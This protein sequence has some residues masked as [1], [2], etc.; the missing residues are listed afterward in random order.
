MGAFTVAAAISTGGLALPLVIGAAIGAGGNLIGQG[1]TNIAHGKNF[2]S[3][4]SWESVV[5]SGVAGAALA[6]G[7]GGTISSTVIGAVANASI[8]CFNDE[9]VSDIFLSGAV[10]G[11]A[12]G[13]GYASGKLISNFIY[14]NSGFTFSTFYK[15]ALLDSGRITAAMTAFRS[16]WYTFLPSLFSSL[17]KTTINLFK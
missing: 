7:V 9:E 1:A 15:S 6:T 17:I 13:V 5:V 4:I 3:D 8:S 11:L 12:G 2:F 16:S 10:G 14:R